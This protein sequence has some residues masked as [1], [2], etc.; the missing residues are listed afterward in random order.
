MTVPESFGLLDCHSATVSPDNLTL[1][2]HYSLSASGH[3]IGIISPIIAMT[4]ALS[5]IRE[6]N[7]KIDENQRIRT[8]PVKNPLKGRF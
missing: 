3:Y 2:D 4:I 8:K 1:S 7:R 6:I 5:F